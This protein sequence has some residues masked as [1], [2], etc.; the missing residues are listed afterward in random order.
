M[1]I[2][3]NRNMKPYACIEYFY[4]EQLKSRMIQGNRN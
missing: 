4:F 3:I 2:E 1:L